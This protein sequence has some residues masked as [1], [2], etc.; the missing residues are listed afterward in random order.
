MSYKIYDITPGI[1]PNLAVY[2]GDLAFSY[3]SSVD[4][5]VTVSDIHTTLHIGAHIDAPLHCM[6]N[7]AAID[8]LNLSYF[9]GTCQ[10]IKFKLV[11]NYALT[12]DDFMAIEITEKRILIAT[13]TFEPTKWRSDYAAFHPETIDFFHSKGV[14]LVGIDTPSV[15]LHSAHS[16]PCHKRMAELGIIG[17]EGL[18]LNNVEQGRYQLIALPLKLEG[19]EASPVRAVLI[20]KA[21]QPPMGE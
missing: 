3:Q 21:P 19:L 7:A 1:S 4:D 11:P 13:E 2:P 8:Q 9:I 17:L 10:L 16:L 18:C 14:I 15:D 12:P 6:P 5:G 20:E